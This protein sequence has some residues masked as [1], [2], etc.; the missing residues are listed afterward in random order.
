LGNIYV[1]TGHAEKLW[2]HG[3]TGQL[4]TRL[5]CRIKDHRWRAWSY[6]WGDDDMPEFIV[7]AR[8]PSARVL[9][10]RTCHRACGTVQTC[11]ARLDQKGELPE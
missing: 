2:G 7:N 6:E 4:L 10:Y 8:S 5:Y 3:R 9:W 11:H 1:S